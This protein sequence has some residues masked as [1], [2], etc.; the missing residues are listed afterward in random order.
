MDNAKKIFAK[1]K[2]IA[3][4][5]EL[6]ATVKDADILII[7]T[8]WNEFRQL[9]LK[10]VKSLIKNPNIIDGRNIYDPQKAKELGFTYIG[11]GR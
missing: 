10:K 7:L 3:Y 4:S 9:D 5:Q 11:V 8:E 1:E 2:N 6:Y